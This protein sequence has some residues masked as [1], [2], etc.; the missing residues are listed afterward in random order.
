MPTNDP[1]KFIID[2][3]IESYTT[4]SVL[5]EEIVKLKSEAEGISK[6]MALEEINQRIDIEKEELKEA[7]R[8]L[9]E[10]QE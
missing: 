10:H 9:K 3:L 6:E 8:F 1:L 2:R 5:K 4:G 7:I